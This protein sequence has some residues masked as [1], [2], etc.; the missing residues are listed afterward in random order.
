[1]KISK[2]ITTAWTKINGNKT[3][4]GIAMHT[5]WF[6]SNLIFKDFTTGEQSAYG[7]MLIGT[8]TGTGLA[9]KGYKN[10]ESIINKFKTK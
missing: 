10:K 2:A 3:K 4:I 5:L 1:M 6:V 7:H 8:I 9:H